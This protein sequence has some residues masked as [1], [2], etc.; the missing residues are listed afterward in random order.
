MFPETF[1]Q[2]HLIW[3]KP[4]ELVLDPFSGRG[5]TV[6]E[7]LLNH[8]D[9][10]GGDTN[11]VAVCVSR[12]KADPPSLDALLDRLGDLAEAFK[13]NVAGRDP[14][15]HDAF[16][17]HCFAPG[18]LRQLLFLRRQLKWKTCRTDRFIS[19][20]AL[21]CLHG[22]SH[23][24]PW[25]F[26]NRMPRTISTKPVYSVAWWQKNRCTPPD[27]D[28]FHI[29]RE[30]AHY[31]YESPVPERRGRVASVDVR[32]IASRFPDARGRV[33][34]MITSPPYLDT[35]NYREDQ[36]LR[37]WLLGGPPRVDSISTKSDDRHRGPATYWKF[38]AAAWAGVAPL[39]RDGA[40]LLIRIGGRRIEAASVEQHLR[41]GLKEGLGTS[42]RLVDRR[43]SKIHNGQLHA[44]RPGAAG[45]QVEHD[46]HFRVA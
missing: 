29:L 6:F 30:V 41:T 3:S 31:R 24:T 11:P 37:L 36:W 18:T 8:R 16:F 44:F 5:T 9:A 34:L 7:S 22:E 17:T 43:A 19:A 33:S 35:T 28:V 46:F 42:V 15:E 27:R 4:G 2:K 10:I 45:T 12:A 20:L 1:V 38:L 39:L 21:G 23:R 32:R 14:L 25:C 13:K 40:H 26:S